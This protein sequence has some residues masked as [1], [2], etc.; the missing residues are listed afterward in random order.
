MILLHKKTGKKFYLE[1]KDKDFNT[2]FGI[3]KKEDLNKEPGSIVKSHLGEEF[4]IF[5]DNFNDI[6]GYLKLGPQSVHKKDIGLLYSLVPIY[7]GMKIVEGGTGSGILTSYLANSVKPN[8]KVYSY[9]IRKDFYKIAKKNFEK[10]KLLDYIELKLK[11]INNGIEEK[12]VDLIVLDTPDPWN[13]LNFAYESLKIGGYLASFLP[14]ITSVLKLLDLN[15]KFLLIGIYE[16][17]VRKWE[18]VRGKVL[19]PENF[20]IVHT[21]FLVLFRRI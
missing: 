11:D 14:N 18:Y 1:N 7:S 3:I 12:N 21:E 5:E 13:T 20:E 6:I 10:L 16:N 2:H 17:F 15:E 8:G 19:R 4:I 9:E